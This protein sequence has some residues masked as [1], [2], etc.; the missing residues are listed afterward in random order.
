M[1]HHL[2]PPGLQQQQQQPVYVLNANAQRQT[3]R[4]AQQ[5]NI[6]AAKSVADVIRTTLGPRA[7]LKMVIDATGSIVLTSDGNAILREIDVGHPAAKSMIELSRTQD[8]EAGDGT[9]SV[10]VLAGEML[11]AAVPCLE[12][13]IHPTVVVAAY[14]R[15]L[16]DA[17]QVI[18]ERC[19]VPI[20]VNDDA[21]MREILE[22][23]VG[24]K[25]VERYRDLITRLV[26]ESTRTVAERL[27]PL[28]SSSAASAPAADNAAATAVTGTQPQPQQ[29]Q[30]PQQQQQPSRTMPSPSPSP[31]VS[32]AVDIKN[33]IRIEKVPGGEL[34]DSEV[35]RGVLVNKDVLHPKMRRRIENP[36]IVLFDCPLEYEKG[37][38]QANV[39]IEK[40]T[41]WEALLKAEEEHVRRM[42]D[43]ILAV[44]PD[45]VI[46]E[47]GASDLAA[48]FLAKAGVTCLRRLRKTDNN[49][50]ARATG[51]RIVSRTDELRESDVGTGA[52]LYEVR[53]LGDEYFSFI[54]DCKAPRACTILL[55]GGSK[56]A[57]NEVERNLHDALYVAR[58]VMR[59][60]RLVPGGGAVE[61][62]VS[63][64]LSERAAAVE[65]AAQWPYRAAA[66]ALEVIPR[67]LAEN[68][69]ASV[70][71]VMT[72]L[73]AA[74]AGGANVTTGIDGITGDIADVV[75]LGVLE[76]YQVKVQGFKTAVESA[77]MLLRIDD[78]LSGVSKKQDADGGFADS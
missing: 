69:G 13:G 74:H 72:K 43:E 27:P 44:K 26:L 16:E 76:A 78:V 61:M 71:R 15:A 50:I 60:P 36:R 41:D 52:G 67:T 38:S 18:D 70:I 75:A 66:E 49:R 29:P 12:R 24:T 35:L 22:S 31:P 63:Q 8:E 62:T 53:K 56:D 77:C 55:R 19:A 54:V 37:E 45:L 59:D 17:L 1:S 11:A 10:I 57:L 33:N 21:K 20:D 25:Y 42:C 5:S 7:M 39:E 4:Q 73:R 9:T 3:G 34:S 58:N 6:A 23:C 48:H 64:A 68:C 14:F 47:K 28:S 30:Q 46:T 65:G 51:A 40:E 32:Y 2:P